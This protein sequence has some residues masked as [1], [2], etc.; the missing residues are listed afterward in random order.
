MKIQAFTSTSIKLLVLLA[1][2]SCKG[3]SSQVDS[4]PKETDSGTRETGEPNTETANETGSETGES[5]NRPFPLLMARDG[6]FFDSDGGEVVLRGVNIAGNSKVPDFLP[7]NDIDD[8]KPLPAWGINVIRLLFIWEAYEPEQGTFNEEYLTELT[9]IADAAGDLGIRV[10]IDIHQDGYARFLARG[11]GDGFPQWTIPPS[12]SL[13]TPDNGEACAAWPA[14]VL[15]DPDVHSA[16]SDFFADTFGVRTQYLRLMASLASHFSTH[17]AVIGYDLLN[18][19]WGWEATEISPLYEDAAVVIREVHPESIL[20]IEGHASTNNGIT[21]TLLTQPAFDNVVYAPHFY[22]A[23]VL[24]TH[25]WSG[26]HQGVEH[27]FKTMTSKAIDWKVPLF[28]G[29]FGTHGDTVNAKDYLELHYDQLDKY[30]A[31]GAQWNYTPKWTDQDKDGW[32]REDLSIVNGQGGLRDN[33]TPRPH[34]R[35]FAGTGLEF[36]AD[37]ET[38]LIR[39]NNDPTVGKT[40]FFLPAPTLWSTSDPQLTTEGENLS[41]TYTLSDWTVRCESDQSG[42]MKVIAEP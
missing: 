1:L 18:E 6:R 27:G 22:E 37:P 12:L 23:A 19:P 30:L 15:A 14:F 20:W 39:W 5:P 8:L 28:I 2:L 11:C 13:D 26:L 9:K 29:E 35:R 33:F 41:C 24:G 7:L 16:F 36:R 34:P 10:I 17:P 38:V 25:I 42:E 21:Q 32:N 3:K 4:G 31:S 40:E